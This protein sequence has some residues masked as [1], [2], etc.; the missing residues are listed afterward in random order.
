MVRIIRKLLFKDFTILNTIKSDK[1]LLLEPGKK[2]RTDDI[3]MSPSQVAQLCWIH[4]FVSAIDV[5]IK[6]VFN[7]YTTMNAPQFHSKMAVA[8]YNLRSF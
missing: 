8:A 5:I 4:K 6:A 2:Q 1:R 3:S 7:L